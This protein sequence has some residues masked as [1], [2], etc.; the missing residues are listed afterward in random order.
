MYADDVLISE[1]TGAVR[2]GDPLNALAWPCPPFR[3][4]PASGPGSARRA[5][6]PPYSPRRGTTARR[7]RVAIIGSGNIGTD[8]MVKILRL[9]DS[10]EV[11]AMVGIDP[12]VVPPHL[13]AEHPLNP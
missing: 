12:V 9:W 2:V 4:A 3:P 6:S 13:D 1:G 5:R 11:A 7:T 10:L 8:L